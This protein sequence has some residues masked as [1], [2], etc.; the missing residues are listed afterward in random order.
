[1]DKARKARSYLKNKISITQLDSPE[2]IDP[3]SSIKKKETRARLSEVINQLLD[4]LEFISWDT[5]S[6]PA[7]SEKEE[8]EERKEEELEQEQRRGFVNIITDVFDY[9]EEVGDNNW[10]FRALSL[11]TF[12]SPKYHAEVRTQVVA[13]MTERSDRFSAGQNYFE[14][15]L[16]LLR[17]YQAW[18]GQQE[19]QAFAEL[20][21]VNI[22]V[23]D[24]MTSSNPMYHISSGI[25]TNQTISLF[26]NGNQYD[27]HLH[28]GTEEVLQLCKRK[29]K[30]VKVKEFLEKKRLSW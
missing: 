24:R 19:L 5:E 10:M 4:T 17:D 8:K 14:S 28:R 23:Y 6:Q 26:Y 1:M 22:N 21:A 30:K 7:S 18:G 20:Y 3:E 29:Y 27:L 11:T 16:I 13:Y 9:Y 15:Y 2:T 12:G 25:S